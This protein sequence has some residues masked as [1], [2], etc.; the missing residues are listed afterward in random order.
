M[1]ILINGNVGIGTTNPQNKVDVEGGAVIGATYSGTNTAPTNGLLV[2]GNVG[3]G[4]TTPRAKLHIKD[5]PPSGSRLPSLLLERGVSGSLPSIGLVDTNVGSVDTAPIW[6]IG[7]AND[8]FLIIRQQNINIAGATVL[9]IDS[10]GAVN[11]DDLRLDNDY[12]TKASWPLKVC[13]AYNNNCYG[14]YI[15]TKPQTNPALSQFIRNEAQF[16]YEEPLVSVQCKQIFFDYKKASSCPPGHDLYNRF[17]NGVS[18]YA[19]SDCQGTEYVATGAGG[20]GFDTPFGPLEMTICIWST[21]TVIIPQ[22]Y[23]DADGC[24]NNPV[25]SANYKTVNKAD[26]VTTTTI[27]YQDFELR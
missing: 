18:Y 23:K 5:Q 6:S 10:S 15:Y 13:S 14:K 26:V 7:N 17:I 9:S 25:Q 1:T 4:T 3:I 2:E 16:C 8:N 11:I 27:S 21:N 19:A 22:S 20:V 12:R 24:H